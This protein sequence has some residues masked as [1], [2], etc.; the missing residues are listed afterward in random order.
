MLIGADTDAQMTRELLILGLAR[1]AAAL[2]EHW[3]HVAPE[4]YEL[5]CGIDAAWMQ[6]LV[7]RATDARRHTPESPVLDDPI[8]AE[9]LSPMDQQHNQLG[10][11]VHCGFPFPLPLLDT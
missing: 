5:A 3:L 6:E 2:R 11:R 8:D 9:H 10:Q 1:G 4:V 7:N